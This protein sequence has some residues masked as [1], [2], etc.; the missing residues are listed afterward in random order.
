[1]AEPAVLVAPAEQQQL[2]PAA[3]EATEALVDVVVMVERDSMAWEPMAATAAMLLLVESAVP[4]ACQFLA[5]QVTAAT[6]VTAESQAWAAT[7]ASAE[8]LGTLATELLVESAESAAMVALVDVT[9]TAATV[10]TQVMAASA[11]LAEQETH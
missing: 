1:M 11:A 10:A 3:T 8:M 2:E 5:L 4:V 6:A 9:A 7:A